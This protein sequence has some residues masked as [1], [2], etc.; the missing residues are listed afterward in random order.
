L[1]R[2][3]L[4]HT[5]FWGHSIYAIRTRKQEEHLSSED[6][7]QRRYGARYNNLTQVK[8]TFRRW[9]FIDSRASGHRCGSCNLEGVDDHHNATRYAL[10]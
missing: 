4:C 2:T 9:N 8:H 7:V 10:D 3:R 1:L 5:V 6:T